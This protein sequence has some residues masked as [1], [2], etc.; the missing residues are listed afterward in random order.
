MPLIK[1]QLERLQYIHELLQG[2]G[3]YSV[4]ELLS[5]LQSFFEINIS[6]RTLI[7]DMN[8]LRSKGAPLAA[9]MHKYKYSAHFSFEYV[10]GGMNVGLVNK[11]PVPTF[12]GIKH[13]NLISF[14]Y[15]L[16]SHNTNQFRLGVIQS[17]IGEPK[18]TPIEEKSPKLILQDAQPENLFNYEYLSDWL[19]H[20]QKKEVIEL[21]YVDFKNKRKHDIFHPYLLKEYNGRWYVYGFSEEDFAKYGKRRIYQ[22]A[23]DR[24]RKFEKAESKY[25]YVINDW[26]DSDEHFRDI[27]GV[28]KFEDKTAQKIIV[29]I[30]EKSIDY[31]LTKK[32]HHSQEV[33]DE[34]EDYIDLSFFLIDN[35]EFRS[36]IFALSANAEIL[37]PEYL[38][39][40]FKQTIELMMKNYLD[41]P[42]LIE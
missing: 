21:T 33:V 2:G 3:E 42:K 40:E 5:K 28:T 19:A 32:L 15:K 1:R 22:Y 37:E 24:I 38:R 12:G 9:R 26:W 8:Y 25:Q 29:R 18:N 17:T 7:N 14:Q 13:N 36:K 35:Y 34:G 10:T 20:I 30:Y 23:V 4:D 6:R 11:M 27:I 39:E 31:L 41:K 16:D